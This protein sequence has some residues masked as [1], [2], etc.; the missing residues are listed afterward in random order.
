[1]QNKLFTTIIIL[2]AFL[3]FLA[4]SQKNKD[5]VMPMGDG[6]YTVS[7][8]GSGL[9]PLG[10]LRAKVYE[11]A[12]KFAERNNSKAEVISVNE[13]PMSFGVNPNVDLKFRLVNNSKLIADSNQNSITISSAY[14]ANGKE[15]DKT[16]TVKKATQTDN[17]K[18]EKLERLGKLFKAGVLTQEEFDAEKKKILA[19]K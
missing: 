7:Q 11:I 3:P 1:M 8:H 13:T 5:I 16:I 6:I 4:F 9:T 12:N 18:L 15:T 14:S 19:E 2:F 10:K 17:E